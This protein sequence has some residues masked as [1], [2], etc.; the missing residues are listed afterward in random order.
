MAVK[1]AK[2][3]KS[4]AYLPTKAKE[5]EILAGKEQIEAKEDE[6]A[7]DTTHPS[8]LLSPSVSTY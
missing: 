4:T 1:A 3:A 7:T 2:S 5:D 8:L 6:K